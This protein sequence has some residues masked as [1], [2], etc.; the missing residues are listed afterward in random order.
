MPMIREAM[1]SASL[2]ALI[3][4]LVVLRL[5]RCSLYWRSLRYTRIEGEKCRRAVGA[6]RDGCG[7]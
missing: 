4:A 2:Q 1:P 7:P 5:G 6:G 3:F